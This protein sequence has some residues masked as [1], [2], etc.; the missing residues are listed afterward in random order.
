MRLR[1]RLVL[2]IAAASLGPLVLL[3]VGATRVSTRLMEERAGEV[4]ASTAQGLALF[5]DTWVDLQVAALLRQGRTFDLAALDDEA[6]LQ[7]LR[8]VYQQTPE[9]R[10]VALVD[11][12]GVERAPG[13]YLGPG[14]AETSGRAPVDADHYARFR[15]ALPPE[16]LRSEPTR[17]AALGPAWVPE[18]EAR[19]VLPLALRLP[20]DGGVLGVELGLDDLSRA[21][22]SERSDGREVSLLDAAGRRILGEGNLADP[23]ALS[24]LAGAA[25]NAS[26]IHYVTSAGE[27]VLASTAP[28]PSAGWTVLVV[29]PLSLSEAAAREI[30]TAT[31]YFGGVAAV[32]SIVLGVLYSRQIS[33]PVVQ[34][35]DGA[36]EVAEGR[37]GRRVELAGSD[38]L[39]ELARAFNFMSH[40]LARNQEEL[41]RQQ[42][43]IEAFNV[44]LQ[45]R[46]EERTREL[47]EAQA[48]LV[49]SASLAAVGELGAGLAHELNNPL[50]G[51]LGLVQVLRAREGSVG[52][53]SPLL[54][55]VEEQARR[56]SD[57][58]GQ[59]LRLSEA[60][61]ARAPVDRR[62]WDVVDLREVTGDVV[63]L[64]G[65]AMR[66]RG[67]SLA[68]EEGEALEVRGERAEL[69]QALTQLLTTLRAA[70]EDGASLVLRGRA[71]GQEVSLEVAVSAVSP[72]GRSD[73]WKASGLGFWAARRTLAAHGGRLVQPAELT[74][75]SRAT[76]TLVLPRA[77]A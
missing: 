38:E 31:L 73:D 41:Q 74:S 33:G 14:V 50:A 11:A 10:A 29:E 55:T 52:G 46:V 8:L 64:V 60:G 36:L 39:T 63:A 4:Q 17:A 22:E 34:L 44:E 5:V 3:G 72:E 47:R 30:R 24:S 51:I 2:I 27:E 71:Q 66:Q 15:R 68:L 67:L 77:E 35:K 21:F 18:G 16:R 26:E 76:W 13:V 23:S 28:V 9:A 61:Q 45:A 53:G 43:E 37:F 6:R 75:G 69:A 32:L 20:G 48:Q 7:V 58:V 42:A 62:E 56:C 65:G 40:R 12:T 70:A 54:A 25:V 1:A 49:Q 59:L 19:P 57:I